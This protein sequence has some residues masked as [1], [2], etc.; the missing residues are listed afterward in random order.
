[1]WGTKKRRIYNATAAFT[2]ST[3][4]LL[5]TIDLSGRFV[6]YN[7]P[8]ADVASLVYFLNIIFPSAGGQSVSWPIGA[9]KKILLSV[10]IK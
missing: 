1:M 3:K 9:R 8:S 4:L 2:N 10:I 7:M 6:R 5:C